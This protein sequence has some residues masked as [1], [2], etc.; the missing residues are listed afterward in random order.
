MELE[1]HEFRTRRASFE[2]IGS[3]DVPGTGTFASFD[4][5]AKLRLFYHRGSNVSR[6]LFTQGEKG[7]LALL[8]L[9][10]HFLVPCLLL[11]LPKAINQGCDTGYPQLLSQQSSM[12]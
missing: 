9:T 10:V 4:K 5:E 3:A 8:T 1:F 7:Y 6:N 11:F 12:T 2:R